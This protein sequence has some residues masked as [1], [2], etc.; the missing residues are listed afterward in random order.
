MWVKWEVGSTLGTRLYNEEL[1]TSS[2]E[3]EEQELRKEKEKRRKKKEM[4]RGKDRIGI[5]TIQ[6]YLWC[7]FY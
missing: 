5:E 6:R 7:P 1:R 4:E 3:K 2:T